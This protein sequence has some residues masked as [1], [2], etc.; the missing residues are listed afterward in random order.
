MKTLSRIVQAGLALA[1]VALVCGPASATCVPG[2]D[3]QGGIYL[4]TNPTAYAACGAL[5]N[6]NGVYVNNCSGL[7]GDGSQP[8]ISSNRQAFFWAAG[9]GNPA[10]TSP[11]P[12][13]GNDSG[14]CS[15]AP[16]SCNDGESLTSIRGSGSPSV[17]CPGAGC[18]YYAG[19]IASGDWG[20][21]SDG[22]PPT[23]PSD[24]TCLLV[25]DEHSNVGTVAFHATSADAGGNYPFPDL[26]VSAAIPGP[27]INS[28]Q[29]DL[30][31][32]EVDVQATLNDFLTGNPLAY[33]NGGPNCGSCAT[34]SY[35]L[36]QTTGA[37][38]A[39]N[40][41]PTTRD[42]GAPDAGTGGG[43]WTELLLSNGNPQPAA[44]T[45]LGSPVSVTVECGA[46]EKNAW[47]AARLIVNSGYQ[48][49]V[50]GGDSTR[51]ECGPNVNDG[52]INDPQLQ[53]RPR[54]RPDATPTKPG[55]RTTGQR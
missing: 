12:G 30:P 37:R 6:A 43:P 49:F 23:G 14:V 34:V 52:D 20:S 42:T 28:S 10:I 41:G 53:P 9:S 32:D 36:Y 31:N 13:A 54:P 1:L 46:G 40:G 21:Q 55:R 39:T 7:P 4:H 11:T 35:K 3:L 24:C 38:P 47:V 8:L 18:Y 5:A 45:P 51:V 25:V 29:R 50:V 27:V 17:G 44:G 26:I 15:S 19:T 2:R 33:S 22:C 48:T 16:D